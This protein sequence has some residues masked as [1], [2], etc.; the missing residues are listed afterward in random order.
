M[1]WLLGPKSMKNIRRFPLILLS[2]LF[3]SSWIKLPAWTSSLQLVTSATNQAANDSI[4]WGQLGAAGISLGASFNAASASGIGVTGALAGP[5][6]LI[7]LACPATSC[8][9]SGGFNAGDAL[10]WT[11]DSGNAGNGPLTL[12]FALP[13]SGAGATVQADGPGA[14]TVQITVFNGGQSLGSF[15]LGSDNAGDP[16]YI[17]V[18]DTA[19]A[20]ITAVTFQLIAAAGNVADF[21]I[22]TVLMNDSAGPTPTPTPTLTATPTPT[23]TTTPTATVTAT[24]TPTPSLASLTIKPTALT[25]KAKFSAKRGAEPKTRKVTLKNARKT[26]GDSSISITNIAVGNPAFSASQNCL[27]V[28]APGKTCKVSVTFTPPQA[29]GTINDNLTVTSNAANAPTAPVSLT[30][31]GTV[32]K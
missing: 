24:P 14:F 29:G 19:A 22:D 27:G 20:D 3:L 2:A 16:V 23:L 10:L 21:A 1:R 6:S 12:T 8:D 18:R 32:A 15:S 28:L 30:G 25:I 31:V 26:A 9:W 4:A 17:G 13:V 11:S 5:D 7:S